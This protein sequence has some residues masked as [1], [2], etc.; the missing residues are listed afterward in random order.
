MFVPGGA[1]WGQM[2]NWNEATA[3]GDGE[4]HAHAREFSIHTMLIG[5]DVLEWAQGFNCYCP[6]IK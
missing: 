1:P 3:A 2:L 4:R 5:A 6:P